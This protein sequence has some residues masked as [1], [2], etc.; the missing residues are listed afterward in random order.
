MAYC[1]SAPY[2][3]FGGG[4]GKVFC[5]RKL[6]LHYLVQHFRCDSYFSSS[7]ENDSIREIWFLIRLE[8]QSENHTKFTIIK[9]IPPAINQTNYS[10]LISRAIFKKCYCSKV[11]RITFRSSPVIQYFFI[12]LFLPNLSITS[13]PVGSP[14]RIVIQL[15]KY[16]IINESKNSNTHKLNSSIHCR[17]DNHQ[18]SHYSSHKLD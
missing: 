8:I 5:I 2:F 17:E 1:S 7:G 9:Q 12:V 15:V 18:T 16:A 14:F 11:T 6:D 10:P 3:F 4:A 13:N